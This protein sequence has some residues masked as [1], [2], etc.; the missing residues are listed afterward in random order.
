MNLF[1]QAAFR[2]DAGAIAHKQHPDHQFRINGWATSMAVK[3]GKMRT[4]T[5][6][7]NEP[8]NR[9]Q[10][11]VLGN[12]IFQ[13]KLIEQCCLCL[14]PWSQNSNELQFLVKRFLVISLVIKIAL[15]L[16]AYFSYGSACNFT[17]AVF[18][19]VT[20]ILY[21]INEMVGTTK[22]AEYAAAGNATTTVTE[23]SGFW[24]FFG[25]D[26]DSGG[27]GGV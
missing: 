18:A 6:Q 23:S 19:G 11:V 24:G 3:F 12:V 17:A 5:P 9:T 26:G 25:G 2:P 22:K 1:A 15:A 13:R 7:I 16:C 27:G 21:V 4:N 20:C 8:I 10:Q 14:L